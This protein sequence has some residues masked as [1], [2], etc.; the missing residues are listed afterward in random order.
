[1]RLC[2]CGTLSRT[3]GGHSYL[4]DFRVAT[5]C[6]KN[7]SKICCPLEATKDKWILW[8]H[9]PKTWQSAVKRTPDWN[10]PGLLLLVQV[11]TNDSRH[12]FQ[13][14]WIIC[15]G[16]RL[17]WTFG[18]RKGPSDWVWN[19]IRKGHHSGIRFLGLEL[20]VGL[21][22]N[23]SQSISFPGRKMAE[24]LAHK[25]REFP[26]PP[27][28]SSF[29]E[30]LLQFHGLNLSGSE[31]V[32]KN[33]V[34]VRLE[35][36][37]AQLFLLITT[38]PNQLGKFGIPTWPVTSMC[39]MNSVNFPRFSLDKIPSLDVYMVKYRIFSSQ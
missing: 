19:W 25:F 23:V 39:G 8:E 2:L 17:Q 26:K 31:N 30:A 21:Y 16:V 29:M 12:D 3:T 35:S 14:W 4:V 27:F 37:F 20:T 7:L 15:G 13:G 24:D 9:P 28:W 32:G 11:L 38:Y 6:R 10:Q 18:L 1:M 5:R 36:K 34:K 22:Q 33:Y